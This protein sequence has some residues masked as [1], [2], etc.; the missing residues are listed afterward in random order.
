LAR[1]SAD[2]TIPTMQVIAPRSPIGTNRPS[3]ILGSLV[4]GIL[5][6]GG[7][8]VAFLTFGTPF[9]S[10]FT[11]GVRPELAQ[12]VAGM[13][14]WTFALIAPAAFIMAG[15]ARI[16][17]TI[18]SV[19]RAKPRATATTR[20]AAALSDDYIVTPRLRLPDGRLVRELVLGPF[21]VAVIEELPPPAASRHRNG[22]WEVRVRGRWLPIENPLERAGRDAER[23]RRWLA[24]DEQDFIV[25]VYA[26]VVAPDTTLPRTP[27][28]AVITNDQ[29]PAWL[30]SLPP[31]RSL[32]EMRRERLIRL[33]REAR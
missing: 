14:A 12:M 7:F 22:V 17:T 6:V 20:V 29:I 16:A 13:L 26:A 8:A 11:P 1:R 31:Q 5:L 33:I 15:L 3:I 32:N 4:G 21:G 27:A 23:V 30:A 2:R 24:D 25:K 9:I 19:G 28:C 18:E 10:R